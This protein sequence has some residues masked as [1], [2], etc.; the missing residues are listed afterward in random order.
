M[1][2]ATPPLTNTSSWRGTYLRIGATLPCT[3]ALKTVQQC[4]PNVTPPPHTHTHKFR[5]FP[6]FHE[7]V[8]NPIWEISCLTFPGPILLRR[9]THSAMFKT[10]KVSNLTRKQIK[11]LCLFRHSSGHLCWAYDALLTYLL[12]GTRRFI[13]VFT[14]ARHWTLS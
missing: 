2:G 14:K 11:T 10:V 3:F 5:A 4:D 7:S 13:T 6:Q 12:Y 1:R 8:W 9:Y